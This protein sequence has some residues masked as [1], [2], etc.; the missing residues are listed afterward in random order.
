MEQLVGKPLH[1]D[2][3]DIEPFGN[4]MVVVRERPYKYSATCPS[5]ERRNLAITDGGD[6]KF[7]GNGRLLWMEIPDS[8]TD[9]PCVGWVVSV[10]PDCCLWTGTGRT[11]PLTQHQLVGSKVLFAAYG[12]HTIN[13]G[14]VGETLYDG[15]YLMVEATQVLGRLEDHS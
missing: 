13:V 8:A 5:C 6:C 1:P 11:I 4:R 10:G 9:V 7:C 12:G 3:F 14:E 15:S 2:I